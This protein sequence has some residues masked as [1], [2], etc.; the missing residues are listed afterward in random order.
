MDSCSCPS[1]VAPTADGRRRG[2]G[3]EKER[4]CKWGK[5]RLGRGRG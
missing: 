1:P 5:G 2:W 3:T 4:V